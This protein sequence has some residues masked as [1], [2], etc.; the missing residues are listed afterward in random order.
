MSS[1]RLDSLAT[2]RQ[3]ATTS[4]SGKAEGKYRYRAELINSQGVTSTK[5][6]TVLV[7]HLA[8]SRPAVSVDNRDGDGTFVATATLKSGIN[9][10]SYAF[11]LDGR[12]VGTGP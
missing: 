7:K 5:T 10:T 1:Q 2:P 11:K 3:S 6:T 4:F 9:A 12:I 8:P